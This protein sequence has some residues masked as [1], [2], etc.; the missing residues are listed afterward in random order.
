MHSHYTVNHCVVVP[1]VFTHPT[2]GYLSSSQMFFCFVWL[3]VVL[4]R[5][6]VFVFYF[7]YIFLLMRICC[8][9]GFLCSKNPEWGFWLYMCMCVCFIHCVLYTESYFCLNV[10][11]FI[12]QK[13]SV[14]IYLIVYI[15]FI[16]SF[17]LKLYYFD[18]E[19]QKNF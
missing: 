2:V 14:V 9:S 7:F 11:N 6:L 12:T 10:D 19:S 13:Q 5:C 17:S 18:S 15:H 1:T 16:S 8:R 3:S 4:L